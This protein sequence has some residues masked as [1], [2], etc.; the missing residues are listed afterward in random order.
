M[1]T[2]QS[3]SRINT[4]INCFICFKTVTLCTDHSETTARE[5]SDHFLVVRKGILGTGSAEPGPVQT[6]KQ[7]RHLMLLSLCF[8]LCCVWFCCSE[9]E[10]TAELP[11]SWFWLFLLCPW[12]PGCPALLLRRLI[13]RTAERLA[14]MLHQVPKLHIWP[15]PHTDPRRTWLFIL[16][17]ELWWERM[18]VGLIVICFFCIFIIFLLEGF[19]LPWVFSSTKIFNSFNASFLTFS[20]F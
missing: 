1:F 13:M 2:G 19:G 3:Q 7:S 17:S 5:Q 14:G 9:L 8:S 20:S 16:Q 12:W 10:V 4:I 15:R 18:F 11:V 6:Q